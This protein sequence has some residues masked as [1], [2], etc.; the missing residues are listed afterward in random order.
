MFDEAYK[1]WSFSLCGLLQPLATS[2]L[3]GPNNLSSL[4]SHTLNLC[5]SLNVRHKVSH[6]YKKQVLMVLYVFQI[7]GPV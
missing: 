5:S 4:V 3:L 2:S 6:S 7:R 1:L